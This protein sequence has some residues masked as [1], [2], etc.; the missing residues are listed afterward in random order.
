LAKELGYDPDS[1]KAEWIYRT[2][3]NQTERLREFL[4]PVVYREALYETER[5]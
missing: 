5:L 4:G 2:V 3:E 1:R